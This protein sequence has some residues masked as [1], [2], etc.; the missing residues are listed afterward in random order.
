MSVAHMLL[1]ENG[2]VTFFEGWDFTGNYTFVDLVA[3]STNALNGALLTAGYASAM[4]TAIASSGENVSESTQA[5]L[6]LSYASAE[7]LAK[8]NPQFA[9]QITSAAQSSFLEGD[10]W[11]YVAALVAVLI[12]M[13]LVYR[14]FPKK[15]E[16]LALRAAYD[17]EDTGAVP[18]VAQPASVKVPAPGAGPAVVPGHVSPPE[19]L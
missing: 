8:Q 6:Q 7:D 5:T 15:D 19:D 16:E 4:G 12:G 9:D 1:A 14:F 13:A 17:A 18:T 10:Q 3:A 11:A 2:T